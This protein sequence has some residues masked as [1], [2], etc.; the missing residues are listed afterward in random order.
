MDRRQANSE[1]AHEADVLSVF[2]KEVRMR[3][4]LAM[5][6]ALQGRRFQD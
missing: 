6:A 3:S 1:R 4:S 2:V 5:M